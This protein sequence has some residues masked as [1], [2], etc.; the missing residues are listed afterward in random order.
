MPHNYDA[1]QADHL[2]VYIDN[3]NIMIL[4]IFDMVYYCRA[5]FCE[6]YDYSQKKYL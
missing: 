5:D 3:K 1:I 2:W 4:Y 6:S